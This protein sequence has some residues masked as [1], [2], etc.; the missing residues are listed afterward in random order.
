MKQARL[1][2]MQQMQRRAQIQQLLQAQQ[3]QAQMSRVVTPV[4]AAPSGMIVQQSMSMI[5]P[6]VAPTALVPVQL[7]PVVPRAVPAVRQKS[8][9]PTNPDPAKPV[10]EEEDSTELEELKPVEGAEPKENSS[11]FTVVKKNYKSGKDMKLPAATRTFLQ[12]NKTDLRS[13]SEGSVSSFSSRSYTRSRSSS[14]SSTSRSRSPDRDSASLSPAS[15]QKRDIHHELL[16][17]RES[18]SNSYDRSR[19]RSRRQR[20][21]RS[22]TDSRSRSRS[23]NS[24]SR[25]SSSGSVKG[26]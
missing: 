19:S 15:K 8:F 25:S 10:P 1:L 9:P 24:S 20:R 3:M 22:R 23:P 4:I 2:Q 5:V 16:K 11:T 17:Q 14:A 12:Q 13:M 6:Q 21:R 26:R 7:A 18:D